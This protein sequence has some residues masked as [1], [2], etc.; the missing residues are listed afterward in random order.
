MRFQ[1]DPHEPDGWIDTPYKVRFY[2]DA[3][4]W[5][6]WQKLAASF[7]PD[8]LLKANS[9]GYKNRL[10]C[11]DGELFEQAMAAR[12]EWKEFWLYLREAMPEICAKVMG[13]NVTKN[14]VRFEWSALPGDGGDVSPHPDTK[15]KAITAV[16]YFNEDWDQEWGG[17][18]EVLKHKT[19]PNDD[20]S[21]YDPP[22]DEVET[23]W[24]VPNISNRIVFMQRT[25]NSLHG[26]RPI[27]APVSRKTI[28]VN[29]IGK[30]F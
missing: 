23:V 7:P 2:D 30:I 10:C 21:S 28:T 18:F 11:R 24:A 9:A 14:T 1:F 17:A 25:N 13:V 12:P 6:E 22:W 3:L 20:F 19:R 29:L 8:E 16:M 4:H 27:H 5:K 26:V 15:K